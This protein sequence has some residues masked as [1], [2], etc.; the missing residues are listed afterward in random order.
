MPSPGADQDTRAACV[1]GD[2]T[3]LANARARLATLYGVA[4]GVTL[5]R[6]AGRTRVRL[7]LP[8]RMQ[9]GGGAPA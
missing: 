7:T 1:Q 4:A 2:G 8:A 5:Q 9:A 6:D 3:G